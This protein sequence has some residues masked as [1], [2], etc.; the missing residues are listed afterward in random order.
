VSGSPEL[1]YLREGI[2]T[3]LSTELD[4][5]KALRITDPRAVL[6][7]SA[8]VSG[9]VPNV[10]QGR[11]VAQRL[12]AGTYVIG[13]IVEGGGRIRIDASAYKRDRPTQPLAR[14]QVEGTTGQLFELV[15]AVARRLLGGLNPGPYEQLPEVATTATHSLPALKAYLEGERLFRNGAFHPAARAFERA[16]IEDSTFALAYYWLSVASWWADDSKAI[17]SAAYHAVQFG[18][19]LSERNR[20]LFEAW[21]AFLRG[22]A[23]ES[24]QVYRE[25]LS[26]EPENVE[27][28]LQ[29]GEVLLHSR[30]RQG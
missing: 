21:S 13:N 29:L 23:H 3:L 9:G 6:G 11:R 20:R 5:V 22:D 24:E 26:A 8:Q 14:A 16:T 18:G 12:G 15:D 7:I 4:G 10:E 28:W 1:G 25:I 27:A 30:P 19:R 17:D 2:V